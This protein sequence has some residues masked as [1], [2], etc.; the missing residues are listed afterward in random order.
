MKVFI[1][2]E[3]IEDL[4]ELDNIK[5][6]AR[7]MDKLFD[8]KFNFKDNRDDHRYG[9]VKD[10]WIRDISKGSTAYRS[11]FI[12]KNDEIYLYRTGTK[13]IEEN[14]VAPDLTG[15]VFQMTDLKVQIGNKINEFKNSGK[16]LKSPNP[17][18]LYD[19]IM[20]FSHIPLK[21]IW[22]VFL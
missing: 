5:T 1:L 17:S 10:A 16:L 14:L 21:E 4:K 19:E 6:L 11:I 20:K 15:T 18:E 22:I 7:V 2:P 12:K 13:K 8:T 3:F 9:G